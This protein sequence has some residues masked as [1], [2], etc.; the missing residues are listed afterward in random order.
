MRLLTTIFYSSLLLLT[1]ECSEVESERSTV[2]IMTFNVENLYE[3]IDDPTGF[4]VHFPAPF[5]PTA[6]RVSAYARLNELVDALPDDRS[7]FAAGDF[8]TTSIDDRDDNMLNRYA[9]PFWTVSNDLC[10]GCKGTAFYSVDDTWSFL[11]MILW[12]SCCG[13][14]AT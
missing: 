9:R 12:K 3:N 4:S 14:H 13:A 7:V 5:H 6:M 11:D 10:A 1:P 2:T 8:N